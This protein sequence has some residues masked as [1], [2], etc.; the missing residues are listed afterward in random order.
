MVEILDVADRFLSKESMTHKKLQRLC[1]YAQA[2]SY[3]L[4]DEP[5]FADE[6][7]AWVHGPVSPRLYSKFAEFGWQEIPAVDIDESVFKENDLK[8]L[9][10][11]YSTYAQFDGDQLET[12]THSEQS[13]I[14]ARGD[15]SPWESCMAVIPF[16]AMRDYY[17]DLYERSQNMSREY[18]LILS[19]SR[20]RAAFMRKLATT[21][22]C[23]LRTNT[24]TEPRSLQIFPKVQ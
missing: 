16:K 6:I 4:F 13:W 5:I 9:R 7:Q 11:V 1:Y 18:E 14:S 15:L 20:T 3:A 23:N 17:L 2:W 12:L 24:S 22:V 19:R 10:S 8:V 21:Y